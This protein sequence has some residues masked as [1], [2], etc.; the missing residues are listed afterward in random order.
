MKIALVT[1]NIF[2]NLTGGV[3]VHTWEMAKALSSIG[4]DVHLFFANSVNKDFIHEESNVHLHSIK[5]PGWHI[6]NP[7]KRRILQL[8][9]NQVVQKKIK[10]NSF[11]IIH[12]QNFDGV[13]FFSYSIPLI[14][15][16]HTTPYSRYIKSK[17][18]FPK[19]IMNTAATLLEH[20]KCKYYANKAQYIAISENVQ[21][22]LDKYYA[23]KSVVIPNGVNK[24][25]KISK[26]KAKERLGISNWEKVILFFSRVTAAKG[27]SKLLDV[28]ENEIGVGL[29]I[30]GEGP[31]IPELKQIVQQKLLQNRVKILGYIKSKNLKYIFSAADCFALPSD[32]VEGQPITILEAMSYGLPCYVTSLSWVPLYLR[33]Y[34]VT[35][36]V[37]KGVLRAL[38]IGEKNIKVMTWLD[39]AEK[40]Q[41]IYKEI[42][43]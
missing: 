12:S 33:N 42:L 29:L 8:Y 2:W 19:S 26:D 36:E 34:A 27:P 11:D 39:V 15:T 38:K 43:P 13:S 14:V 31:F 25:K 20:C 40:T 41:K 35:G 3:E 18:K 5:I 4:N 32:Q 24:C 1:F 37:N 21:Y 23:I 30:C 10:R 17:M 22:D 7:N 9:F 6:I 16:I 28:I